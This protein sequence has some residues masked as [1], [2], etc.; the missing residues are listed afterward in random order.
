MKMNI[1]E[2]KRDRQQQIGREKMYLEMVQG[3]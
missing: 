2:S 3:E 1:V